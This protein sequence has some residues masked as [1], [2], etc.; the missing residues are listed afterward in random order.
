MVSDSIESDTI[1]SILILQIQKRYD[2]KLIDP[3]RRDSTLQALILTWHD[4]PH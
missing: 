4:K 1:D 3:M 2:L